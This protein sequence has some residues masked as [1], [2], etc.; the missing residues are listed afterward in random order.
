MYPNSD[1]LPSYSLDKAAQNATPSHQVA[2]FQLGGWKVQCLCMAEPVHL[3][4]RG[5]PL[6][7]SGC[8]R[9]VR[10]KSMRPVCLDVGPTE[11]RV[12]PAVEPHGFLSK[13]HE[14]LEMTRWSKP[15]KLI[16]CKERISG[17]GPKKMHV[18]MPCLPC[19]QFHFLPIPWRWVPGTLATATG[20]P[21]QHEGPVPGMYIY[22]R[23]HICISKHVCVCV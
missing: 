7:S 1:T 22:I 11:A 2:I 6:V 17:H 21:E 10:H 9:H 8:T 12:L 19:S 23:D 14:Y 5:K 13:L 15:Y 4:G 16:P 18:E 20:K 3:R